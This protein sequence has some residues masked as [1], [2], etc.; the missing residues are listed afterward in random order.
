[1]DVLT[2]LKEKRKKAERLYKQAVKNLNLKPTNLEKQDSIKKIM[3][4]L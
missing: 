4:A 2:D 3:D 1:M